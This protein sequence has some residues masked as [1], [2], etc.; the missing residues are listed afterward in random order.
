MSNRALTLAAVA[1]VVACQREERRFVEPPHLSGMAEGSV[2]S[3]NRPGHPGRDEAAFVGG[4]PA[5]ELGPAY[6]RN[7]WTIAQGKQLFTWFNCTGCH[8]NG[9]GGM[10]PA[11]M[12][13][14]WLYGSKPEDIYTSIV[15]GRP[16]GMPSFRGKITEPQ[17]WQ[18]VGYVRS[19]SGL[20]PLDARPGRTDHMSPHPPEAMLP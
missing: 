5:F 3:S 18:L 2:N 7:A 11:L 4:P 20:V 10:G 13:Q 19:M 17:V 1:V 6:N 16:Q 9:G 12:D 8:A 14:A 15:E